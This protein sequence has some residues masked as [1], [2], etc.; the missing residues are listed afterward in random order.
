MIEPDFDEDERC[1]KCYRPL[2]RIINVTITR[3]KAE[4]FNTDTGDW[5]DVEDYDGDY[6]HDEA[7]NEELCSECSDS[8]VK[9]KCTP[10]K[11]KTM[12]NVQ[13]KE[14]FVRFEDE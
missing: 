14:E 11:Y 8:P 9:C 13:G 2:M 10:L 7:T 12:I 1:K 6:H 4:I 3:E 5:E